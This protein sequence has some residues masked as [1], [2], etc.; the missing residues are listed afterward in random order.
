MEHH[1]FSHAIKELLQEG[2]D[3]DDIYI[4][5]DRASHLTSFAHNKILVP[6]IIST[7]RK[8]YP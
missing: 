5:G 4:V 8:N 7:I 3:L 1:D 6:Y 2:F